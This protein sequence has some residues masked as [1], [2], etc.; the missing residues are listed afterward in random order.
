VGRGRGA[1]G[2]GRAIAR[3]KD[4]TRTNKTGTHIARQGRPKRSPRTI[5][6]DPPP[7]THTHTTL[8]TCAP[9]PGWHSVGSGRACSQR[10]KRTGKHRRP[11]TVTVRPS[12]DSMLATTTCVWENTHAHTHARTHKFTPLAPQPAHCAPSPPPPPAPNP[13]HLHA[14]T[15]GDETQ[16][17]IPR[18]EQQCQRTTTL[19]LNTAASGGICRNHSAQCTH[20]HTHARAYRSSPG[21]RPRWCR[22][23]M[24]RGGSSRWGSGAWGTHPQACTPPE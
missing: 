7:H 9:G 20:T 5:I 12:A 2:M 3:S 18:L 14:H 11:C 23:H 24:S 21:C 15:R 6:P 17:I 16:Y 22:S 4:G 1:D 13:T 10:A 8:P 19:R